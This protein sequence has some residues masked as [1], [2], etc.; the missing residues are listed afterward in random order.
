[1]SQ[2]R[3]DC[4]PFPF[5]AFR[6]HTLLHP[7]GAHFRVGDIENA[8]VIGHIV[9][10]TDDQDYGEGGGARLSPNGRHANMESWESLSEIYSWC[11][12]CRCV[13]QFKR[14]CPSILQMKSSFDADPNGEERGNAKSRLVV[15]NEKLFC[16]C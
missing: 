13:E 6:F 4:V 7:I 15:V 12:M 16:P 11:D 14:P 8:A 3:I 5:S 1:M 2:V 10:H 9:A